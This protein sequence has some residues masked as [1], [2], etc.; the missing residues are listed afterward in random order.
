M[1]RM[2]LE[3]GALGWIGMALFLLTVWV[4]T[5]FS[6]HTSDHLRIPTSS[7]VRDDLHVVI[8]EGDLSFCDQFDM[9]A[10]GNVRP[11]VADYLPLTRAD[12]LRG[13]RAG[14]FT[15][16]GLDLRYYRLGRDGYLIWSLTLSMLIP[17][18]LC[19]LIAAQFRNRLKKMRGRVARNDGVTAARSEPL[20]NGDS[21]A[22][23]V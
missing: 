2:I 17:V 12:S 14:Q 7:S 9:D 19:L 10:A 5:K 8:S 13:D 22:I 1:K 6:V 4:V 11:M 18:A 16:P 23:R 3:W 21:S 20:R 15:I